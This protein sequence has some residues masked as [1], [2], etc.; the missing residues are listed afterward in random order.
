[1][2]TV[3]TVTGVPRDARTPFERWVEDD[4]GLEIQRSYAAGPLGRL[5]VRP[6]AER[7]ISAV[8]L[9]LIGAESLAGMYVAELAPGASSTQVRQ[10][11]E[12]TFYVLRGHG[13]TT[14]ETPHGTIAFEWGPRSLFAI[15]LN[16]PYRLHNGSG[17]ESA[18]LISVNTLPLIYSL[19]RD[20]DFVFN[21]E[22][23]FD[24]FSPQ[25]VADPTT[26]TLYK[27]DAQH[28]RTAVDLYDTLFVPDILKLQRT[29]FKERGD[30][31]TVYIETVKSAISNHV[32]EHPG[33]RFFNP[34]RHG[35]SAFVFTIGGLGYSL[36]WPDGGEM[37]RFDWPDDD[38]GVIVPPNMWWHGHFVTSP[39][40]M[41]LAIKLRSRF[42]PINHLFDK[43][44]IPVAEG[45]KV[46]RF[47]DLD[48]DLKRRIWDTYVEECRK[49]GHDVIVPAKVAV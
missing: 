7:N 31:N 36:M 32:A 33:L 2:N 10:V 37:I 12:E 11:C 48:D 45:G 25:T 27:P 41:Q 6:W 42:N 29:A 13:S 47:G 1:M 19:F 23:D 39:T 34:H 46:L 22:H 35:P 18:R 9:D 24:R 49:Q 16:C 15:P 38:V 40:S 20:G 14:I 30:G 44:H 4:L 3:E 21:T 8:F 26:A 17:T 28:A 43:S 5:D